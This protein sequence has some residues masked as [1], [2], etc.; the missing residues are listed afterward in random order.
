MSQP[1]KPD[2]EPIQFPCGCVI[3]AAILRACQTHAP[4]I[5]GKP[6][7]PRRVCV[8]CGWPGASSTY[9]APCVEMY[10]ALR[11]KP[12][13]EAVQKEAETRASMRRAGLL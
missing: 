13:W 7:P 2:H 3:E 5:T 12:Y 11:N 8:Q 9:C 1:M 4:T 10:N 6:N